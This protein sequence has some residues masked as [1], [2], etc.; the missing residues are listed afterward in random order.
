[1]LNEKD[2]L[3]ILIEH[4]A[5]FFLLSSSLEVTGSVVTRPLP[6]CKLWDIPQS[7]I[8]QCIIAIYHTRAPNCVLNITV[9]VTAISHSLSKVGNG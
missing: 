4:L 6:L 9:E 7:S 5:M 8:A 1:M 3:R 2:L